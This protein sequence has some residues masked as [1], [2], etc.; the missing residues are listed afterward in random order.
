MDRDCA[1][2]GPSSTTS[3]RTTPRTCEAEVMLASNENPVEPARPRCSRKLAERVPRRSRS[4]AIPDP[5]AQRAARADRRGQRPRAGERARRQRRRRAHL[6]PAAGVGRARAARCSTC[7]RRSRCTRSTPQ[8]TGTE[9]RAHPAHGGLLDRRG[10]RCSSALAR[11]RHRHRHRRQPEQPDRRPAPTRRS[12]STCSRRPTRIVLVDEAYFEFS[13]H[14]MR[15]HMERH[16]NLVILRT[17]SK[18]FSLAGLRVGYLLG[19]RGRRPRADEGA[20]AVLGGLVLSQMVAA[21]VFRERVVFEQRHPRHHPRARPAR[22]RARAACTASRSSRAR[23]TSCCSASSTRS[24]LWRDLLHS[25]SVLVRD[26]SR[27]PGLE[28]CLRV[29]VGHGRGERALP[30]G[31]GRGPDEPQGRRALRRAASQR[32]PRRSGMSEGRRR[33][34][35]TADDRARRPARPTSRVTLDL[36][37]SGATAVATGVPFFDHMLD[38][39]GRHGAVRPRRE[40]RRAT[41]R[42]TR[43]TPSRTSASCSGQ[44]IARGARRQGAASARFGSATRADGRGARARAPS[45]SPAAAQLHYDGRAADRDHRDVRHHAGQGVPRRARHQR[46]PHAARALARRRERHHIIEAAF[47][48]VARALR[49]AVAL[50]P[51]VSGVPSHE[52]HRCD[53]DRRLPDGQPAQRR[54][55]A[56]STRASPTSS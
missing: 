25:H 52:G 13:R 22:P 12:S 20:P 40:G 43:T 54:R 53:R 39:F 14:T 29:T 19:A 21:T 38:A 10:R 41:S 37:G 2:P 26:F 23:R 15:P 42:S 27:T 56:S 8:V 50:D 32:A 49:E 9:R 1:R 55:R 30:R 46:G 33:M 5:T 16:P 45:T 7:R 11:G 36:D 47:K 34:G 44:A 18:A 48:A 51:R 28:D 17:F 24:A 31:D 35:R 6:R 3:S 4:T